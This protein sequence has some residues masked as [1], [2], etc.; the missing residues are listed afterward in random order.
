MTRTEKNIRIN[1]CNVDSLWRDVL[2]IDPPCL[3]RRGGCVDEAKVGAD[4]LAPH[5]VMVRRHQGHEDRT[6][7]N[8][9]AGAHSCDSV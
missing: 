9:D 4:T 1:R 6:E 7:D 3:R 8:E 2:D 5:V